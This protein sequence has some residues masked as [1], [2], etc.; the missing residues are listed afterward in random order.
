MSIEKH[1]TTAELA[2][3]LNCSTDTILRLAQRGEIR[4]FFLGSDRRYAESAVVEYMERG[5]RRAMPVRAS[6]VLPIGQ[7]RASRPR[8]TA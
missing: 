4:S 3:S 8:R 2:E 6:N 1:Y 7:T 5:Q